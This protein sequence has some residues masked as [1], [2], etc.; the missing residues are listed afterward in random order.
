VQCKISGSIQKKGHN[1]QLGRFVVANSHVKTIDYLQLYTIFSLV[2]FSY[3][4]EV[5]DKIPTTPNR[6]VH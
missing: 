3:R 6:I 1:R 4:V 2:I 5:Q